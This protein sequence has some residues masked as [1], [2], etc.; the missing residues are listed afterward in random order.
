MTDIIK[1]SPEFIF[2]YKTSNILT[3]SLQ[4]YLNGINEFMESGTDAKD[5][6]IKVQN[7]K[8]NIKLNSTKWYRKLFITDDEKTKKNINNLLN[9]LTEKNY[10]DITK[11]I[12][13]LQLNSDI[14]VNY[15]VQNIIDKCL[16]ESQYILKW[17]FVIKHIVFNNLEK[18]TYNNIPIY[19]KFLEICQNNLEELL[20]SD[21]NNILINLYKTSIDDF[22]K[23]KNNACSQML[24]LTE[25]YKL[26][27]LNQDT[28]KSIIGEF[29]VD[30][31]KHYKLE[32]G[33]III[34]HLLPNKIGLEL[35]KNNVEILLKDQLLNKKIKFMIL[36]IIQD[37]KIKPSKSQNDKI[38]SSNSQ[39]NNKCEDNNPSEFTQDNEIEV[40][41]RNIINEFISENDLDYTISCYDEIKVL[42]R[43]NKVIFEFYINLVEADDDKYN[44]IFELII[45][46]IRNKKIKYNNIK[47]GLIDF[48]REYDELLLDYPQVDNSIIKIL[49]NFIKIKVFDLNTLKFILLKGVNTEKYD[50]FISNINIIDI[51]SSK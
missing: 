49:N 26:E 13:C 8:G 22:Y 32:L 37:N 24:L 44:K 29:I 33:I 1:Y 31:T 34:K 43:S 17:S 14:M 48:L 19:E 21:Y 38:K 51:K 12:L 16:L 36:D 30:S 15:L 18:W 41:V 9:K 46:L 2:K 5:F 45:K 7:Q 39:N 23:V 10:R 50:Y 28:I 40:K 3:E 6:K 11:D 20:N 4:I 27:L 35:Y 42:L 47:F 25:L